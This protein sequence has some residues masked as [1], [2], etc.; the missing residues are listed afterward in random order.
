[1]QDFQSC[2]VGSSP[3]EVTIVRIDQLVDRYLDTVKVPGS[4]PGADTKKKKWPHSLEVERRVLSQL[5]RVRFPVR[6][7]RLSNVTINA[8]LKKSAILSR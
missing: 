1:M 4:S 3:T 6:S 7:Q 2:H 5:A 8:K